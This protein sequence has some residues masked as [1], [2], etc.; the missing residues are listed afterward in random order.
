VGFAPL[1]DTLNCLET[2]FSDKR[3]FGM[4]PTKATANHF[5]FS[6]FNFQLNRIKRKQEE[7][8]C[9]PPASFLISTI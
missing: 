7:N 5:Q 8:C 1:W 2:G 6:I 4:H 3:H 9:F